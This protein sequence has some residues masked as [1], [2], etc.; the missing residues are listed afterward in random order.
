MGNECK[1]RAW[2]SCRVLCGSRDVCWG[3]AESVDCEGMTIPTKMGTTRA[4][5]LTSGTNAKR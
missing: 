3:R 1:G 5:H 2:K 4:M